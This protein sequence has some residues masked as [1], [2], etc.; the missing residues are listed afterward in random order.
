MARHTWLHLKGTKVWKCRAVLV[1]DRGCKVATLLYHPLSSILPETAAL[2]EVANEWLYHGLGARGVVSLLTDTQRLNVVGISRADVCVDFCPTDSQASIIKGLADGCYY[3]AGKRN[4]SQFWGTQS[5]PR[6]HP[7]WHGTFAHCLSWGHKTSG[8]KWKCYYKTLELWQQGGMEFPE[9]PYIIDQWRQAGFDESNVWRLEVSI[10]HFGNMLL[11]GEP[12]SL[13]MVTSTPMNVFA[14]MYL[15]RFVVKRNEGHKDKTN[16]TSVE[17][18]PISG[19]I[20]R[21]RKRE[22]VNATITGERV[23]L[24]RK[25]C[26]AT[27]EP[28]VLASPTLVDSLCESIRTI[29]REDHLE[30]YFARITGYN[31]GTYIESVKLMV[32]QWKTSAGLAWAES[33]RNRLGL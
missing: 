20:E 28:A 22:S 25:L 24:L 13:D 1:N 26:S 18:L 14:S 31:T 16:D 11:N 21:W 15:P 7:M 6:L 29:V 4:G 2:L 3:I 17:F 32:E 10:T 12:L 30:R 19:D 8:V 33:Q 23:S 5:S 27:L 9:K